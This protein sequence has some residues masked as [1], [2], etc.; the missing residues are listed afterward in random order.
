MAENAP[1]LGIRAGG[2]G[3]G[4]GRWPS[5]DEV[6]RVLGGQG[7]WGPPLLPCPVP[8]SVLHSPCHWGAGKWFQAGKA[9]AFGEASLSHLFWSLLW[10]SWHLCSETCTSS[11]LSHL[12]RPPGGPRPHPG[13]ML[14]VSRGGSP[15]GTQGVRDG[16]VSTLGWFQE[17]AV[18]TGV[19]VSSPLRTYPS[20]LSD[21]CRVVSAASRLFWGHGAV[22]LSE[23][24]CPLLSGLSGSLPPRD[25]HL[26]GLW[27]F[28]AHPT[29]SVLKHLL[30]AVAR[31]EG[32]W[33]CGKVLSTPWRWAHLCSPAFALGP[34][35]GCSELASA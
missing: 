23:L 8:S 9:H 34:G 10:L 6:L 13:H 16:K 1:G 20:S 28:L 33:L 18:T 22:V 29:A 35:G 21:R 7:G 14:H 30:E 19:S 31:L 25:P 4:R 17:D 32:P 5:W 26:P 27:F 2:L 24:H 11:L 15:V 3:D 12:S